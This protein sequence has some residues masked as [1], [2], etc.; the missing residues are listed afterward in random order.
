MSKYLLTYHGGSQPESEAARKEVMAQWTQWFE[1]IGPA[2]V[3]AGNPDITAADISVQ[4]VEANVDG[5]W[6]NVPVETTNVDLLNLADHDIL[7][8]TGD[9]PTGNYGQVRV[10]VSSATVTD[11][12]GVHTVKIPSG[13]Q[14][15][16]KLNVNY[17]I[18]RNDI[19]TLL[20]DF[21]VDQSI[22]KTGNGKYILKP[23]IPAVVKVLSGT[24]SGTVHDADGSLAP[25]THI[26]AVYTAGTK[27]A[28]GTVVNTAWTG[29]EGHFKVWAL[30]PG[31]YRLDLTRTKDGTTRTAT[32]NSV[33]V[34][35]DQNTAV[36]DI[37]LN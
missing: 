24:I 34:S 37:T 15:G 11:S 22:V 32:V 7:L 36:G 18:R 3:D 20:L 25:N 13:S 14:T 2:V 27:Y 26:K 12:E 28:V 19:T 33:E 16:I 4:K 17:D 29:D 30:L 5:K 31:T 21:N 23:V 9:V 10:F 8:A 6:V 35:A 1:H